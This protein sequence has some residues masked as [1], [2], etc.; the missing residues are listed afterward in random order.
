M[1]APRP[2]IRKT[3]REIGPAASVRINDA[4]YRLKRRGE[5]VITLSL[6][7][8]F[9]KQPMLPISDEEFTA[10]MHY[11]DS[12]GV[13]LLREKISAHYASAFGAQIDPDNEVLVSAGSKPIL[14]MAMLTA[15]EYGEE[16][17]IHEPGWLSYPEQARLCGAVPRHIP[18]D[19]D[20]DGIIA[21]IGPA[22]GMLIINNP[23]N[24]AG[25]LY[26][27]DEI[28]ALYAACRKNGAYLLLDESYS[29]FAPEGSFH[30]LASVAPGLE[31]AL[32]INSLSKNLGVS[33][34]RIG[35]LLGTGEFIH[36]LLKLNQHLVTCAPTLLANYCAS[37]FE[38]MLASTKPQ[39]RALQEKRDRVAAAI[40]ERGLSALDGSTTF[41]FFLSI[42][43]FPGTDVEFAQ[44]LIV[45]DGI[46]V[47]PGSAYGDST[48]RFVRLSI[49]TESEERI[50]TALDAIRRQIGTNEFD[51]HAYDQ[52]LEE[53][54]GQSLV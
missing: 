44:K 31:G 20:I 9:F 54:I 39:I 21:E 4:V 19:A 11:S 37:H 28:G 25:R 22:T 50:G 7:E 46:A 33:G 32:V 51:K 12:R 8:A 26:S 34:W 17:L 23:N 24:P 14:F 35:Y 15:V 49:G 29:D 2:K 53:M 5:D 43:G 3:V 41:Y 13:P 45:D 27:R 38:E 47:V 48:D 6:G 18:Y 10:G 36:H 1:E 16:I 52:K 42:G 40:A 30:S